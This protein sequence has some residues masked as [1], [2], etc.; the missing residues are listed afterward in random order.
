ML[1]ELAFRADYSYTLVSNFIG[2]TGGRYDNT[3][4]RAMHM[5]E[6]LGK[7]YLRGGHRLELGYTWFRMLTADRGWWRAFPENWFNLTGVFHLSDDLLAT[8][9]LRVLGA[10][11]DP[12]RIVEYRNR[13]YNEFGKVINTATDQ[14]EL[15]VSRVNEMVLDRLPPGADLTLGLSYTGFRRLTLNAIAY[16]SL[17][18]RYFQPDA[19]HDYEPRYEMLPNPYED[20]RFHLNATYHY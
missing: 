17:N 19:F 2:I 6:F 20:F 9:N 7:I 3:E 11:E 18:A 8:S 10:M 16:N 14:R 5:A 4:D 1:R 12:N 15:T 13:A